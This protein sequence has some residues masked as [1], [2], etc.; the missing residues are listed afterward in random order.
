MKVRQSLI[1]AL[2]IILTGA[3]LTLG[4]DP[5]NADNDPIEPWAPCN[6]AGSYFTIHPVEGL[7]STMTIIADDP[8]CNSISCIQK[9]FNW[10]H[11][12]GGMFPEAVAAS[13]TVGTGS[14][15]EM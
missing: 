14:I 3:L 1:V 10:N 2:I 8:A 9:I 6:P 5:T 13:D 15:R 7:G 4:D 12:L 11:T